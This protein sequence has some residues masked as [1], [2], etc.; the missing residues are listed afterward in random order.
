MG[1]IFKLEGTQFKQVG[2]GFKKFALVTGPANII[3]VT[4][5]ENDQI[6]YW[7]GKDWKKF[8]N[9]PAF[10]IAIARYGRTFIRATNNAIEVQLADTTGQFKHCSHQVP[11]KK[12]PTRLQVALKEIPNQGK[13]NQTLVKI[14]K[15]LQQRNNDMSHKNEALKRDNIKLATKKNSLEMKMANFEVVKS[16]ILKLTMANNLLLGKNDELKIENDKIRLLK[17]QLAA[18]K[19]KNKALQSGYDEITAKNEALKK[20]TEKQLLMGATSL[21]TYEQ[22]KMELSKK[23]S[24]ISKIKSNHEKQHQKLTLT[25]K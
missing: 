1:Q 13:M 15:V 4:N 17:L 6:Y 3:L 10:E 12:P 25:I 5:Y 19:K 9:T 11:Q 2:E 16:H 18:I 14:T 23:D 8:S 20:S 7:S 24:Y 22:M 21:L